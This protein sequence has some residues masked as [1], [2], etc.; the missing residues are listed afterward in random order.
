MS[1][2]FDDMFST[3]EAEKSAKPPEVAPEVSVDEDED[4]ALPP[5]PEDFD[6]SE[7]IVA[8]SRKQEEISKLAESIDLDQEIR[9]AKTGLN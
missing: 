5:P 9:A 4:L 3:L 6:L 1:N 7:P 2:P 8:T